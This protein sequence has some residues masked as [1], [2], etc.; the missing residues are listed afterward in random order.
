VSARSA[1]WALAALCAAWALTLW[2]GPWADERVSDLFVYRQL[3]E[4]LLDGGLPYRDVFLE[5]PP[6]AAGVLALPGLAGTGEEAY[7]LAFAGMALALATLVLLLSGALA[8]RTGG[9]P[10][11]A[12]LGVAI[13]PLLCGAMVRTHFDLAPVALTLASLLLVCSGRPRAGLAALGLGAM[14]KGFPLVVA[15]VVLAWLVARGERRAAI[16]G[17]LALVL[18][19]AAV[20][21]A[22]LAASPDGALDAVRYQLE[23]P[24]QIE[25]VPAGVLLALDGLGAGTATAVDSH[26]SDGLEH[27]AGD[28]LTAVFGLALLAIVLLL[29]RRVARGRPPDERSLVLASLAAVAAFAALGKVLSPQF[30]IWVVP[31][32]ALALAW[33]M[34]ALAAACACATALTL[35][36]FPSRYFDVVDREPFALAVV[37]LRNAALLCAV[38]LAV[39]GLTTRAPL[40]EP[41]AARSSW[42]DRRPGFRPAPR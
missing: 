9:D 5:Y 3:A 13:A 6:L 30:L 1:L 15:P 35:V 42:P 17:T 16:E 39:R 19:V 20:G 21:G 10:R 7:R 32:G 25:S 27:A 22:A 37:T 8:A 36:E 40:P 41:G 38:A 12:M 11:R 14:T 26:R 2:V 31:L 18:V 4:P 33:R 29:A 28:A 34:R 24:V 23:R